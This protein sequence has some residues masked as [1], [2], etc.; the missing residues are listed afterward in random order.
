MMIFLGTNDVW[1]ADELKNASA[2]WKR[3]WRLL[4]LPRLN[5]GE[6]EYRK[7]YFDAV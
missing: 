1:V 4:R 6:H 5:G 3:L 7:R 2:T